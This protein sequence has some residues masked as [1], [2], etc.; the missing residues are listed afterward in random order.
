MYFLKESQIVTADDSVKIL[1]IECPVCDVAKRCLCEIGL[2]QDWLY[3]LECGSL[4]RVADIAEYN[5]ESKAICLE[6]NNPMKN[7]LHNEKLFKC[8]L[9]G[10]GY[11]LNSEHLE[12]CYWHT[13]NE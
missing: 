1:D 10:R 12:L 13:E 6:C 5:K 9:C 8:G 11:S 4:F 2:G 7:L 3:C